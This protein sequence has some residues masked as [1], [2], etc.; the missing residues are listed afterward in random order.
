M[1]KPGKAKIAALFLASSIGFYFGNLTVSL[2]LSALTPVG[3]VDYFLWLIS[4][5][6]L[7]GAL[8]CCTYILCKRIDSLR[9]APPEPPETPK[10]E[11]YDKVYF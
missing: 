4:F 11:G 8:V 10:P 1:K 3:D 2:V 5:A 9:D 6:L 7:F